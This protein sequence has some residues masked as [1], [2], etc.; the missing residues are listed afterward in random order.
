M[1]SRVSPPRSL[2]LACLIGGLVNALLL[3]GAAARRGARSRLET[4]MET[5]RENRTTL[6]A[7]R[8]ERRSQLESA[9]AEAQGRVAVAAT[10]LPPDLARL[11]IFRLG[12]ELAG[13]TVIVTSLRRAGSDVR[14]TPLGPVEIT[15]QRITA[16]AGLDACLG[17]I[18]SLEAISPGVGLADVSIRPEQLE[19]DFN[20]LTLSRGR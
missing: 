3:S 12:F 10:A 7:L 5:L 16:L 9:L 20:V 1:R 17:Y 13:D 8:M 18:A 4:T 6:S 2:L 15:T 14:E 11:D 19:C